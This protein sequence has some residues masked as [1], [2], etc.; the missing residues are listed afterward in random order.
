MLIS[1]VAIS[2]RTVMT[3]I[4]AT[5]PPIGNILYRCKRSGSPMQGNAQIGRRKIRRCTN[6]TTGSVAGN[7]LNMRGC[8]FFY[9]TH[10]TNRNMR[11]MCI[12]DFQRSITR[13]TCAKRVFL[14]ATD[15]EIGREFMRKTKCVKTSIWND[16]VVPNAGVV[17][18]WKNP[19]RKW[20]LR[21]FIGNRFR[22][23]FKQTTCRR[24][25]RIDQADYKR[26]YWVRPG[27][28]VIRPKKQKVRQQRVSSCQ[29]VPLCL[30]MSRSNRYY[31]GC[32]NVFE[33][34]NEGRDMKEGY[35]KSF[36]VCTGDKLDVFVA[37]QL[38]PFML[39]SSRSTAPKKLSDQARNS[40]REEMHQYCNT[41]GTDDLINAIRSRMRAKPKPGKWCKLRDLDL[42]RVTGFY[43]S[44]E[45]TARDCQTKCKRLPRCAAYR[46]LPELRECQIFSSTQLARAPVF[47]GGD[48]VTKKGKNCT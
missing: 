38:A 26:F 32:A 7:K 45:A 31:I 43:E 28:G 22:T 11:Y 14:G 21:G 17:R 6:K 39:H 37:Q 25:S 30:A 2:G 24:R 18:G 33:D 8:R 12:P 10:P 4:A 27:V 42:R 16:I 47:R 5:P 3:V 36:A 40:R 35:A 15:Y 41:V 44:E 13:A 46:Y 1:H 34:N 9:E 23:W 29:S 20:S 48:V 19:G